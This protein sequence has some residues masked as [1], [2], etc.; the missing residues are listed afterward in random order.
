M[1]KA[2]RMPHIATSGGPRVR[3]S[4]GFTESSARITPSPHGRER[5]TASSQAPLCDPGHIDTDITPITLAA[6]S[7]AT[8]LAAVDPEARLMPTP[9]SAQARA[10]DG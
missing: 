9:G 6:Y 2:F 8:T 1:R 10:E 5:R 7:T 3:I 4:S